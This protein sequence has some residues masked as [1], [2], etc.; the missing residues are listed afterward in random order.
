MP[1]TD[2]I[3]VC[4]RLREAAG[5]RETRIVLMTGSID[6]VDAAEAEKAGADTCVEKTPDFG[7]I[8]EAVLA[9][10][11]QASDCS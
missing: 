9:E 4:R 11:G 5:T 8:L 10:W 1:D 6:K 3:E 2:G 7:L